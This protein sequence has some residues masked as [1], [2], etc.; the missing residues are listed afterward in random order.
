MYYNKFKYIGPLV[1]LLNIFYSTNVSAVELPMGFV[2]LNCEQKIDGTD[3]V[4]NKSKFHAVAYVKE[5]TGVVSVS[6]SAGYYFSLIKQ[7]PFV[8]PFTS[9]DFILENDR[10][11]LV[12]KAQQVSSTY[13]NTVE[14][15]LKINLESRLSINGELYTTTSRRFFVGQFEDSGSLEL[16]DELFVTK[17]NL[18]KF[19]CSLEKV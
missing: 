18:G 2:Q 8:L 13:Y 14:Y 3:D 9:I 4:K 12:V 11:S 6:H 17:Q 7:Q 15:D 19:S 1:L 5:L 16:D 10:K